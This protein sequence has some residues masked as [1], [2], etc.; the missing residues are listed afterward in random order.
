MLRSYFSLFEE[1][2]NINNNIIIII[3]IIIIVRRRTRR[4]RRRKRRRRRRRRKN[5]EEEDSMTL[6]KKYTVYHIMA[7][8]R[9][10]TYVLSILLIKS[11]K[12]SAVNRRKICITSNVACKRQ[13]RR[14]ITL[15]NSYH[16]NTQ[17]YIQ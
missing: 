5:E 7:N 2:E 13:R 3:I 16:R 11:L 9:R 17:W 4:R 1:E 10:Q 12:L 6:L 8:G 14:F 15:Y